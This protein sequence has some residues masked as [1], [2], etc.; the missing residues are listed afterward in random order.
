MQALQE[1]CRG[2]RG[3]VRLNPP[4][5]EPMREEGVEEDLLSAVQEALKAGVAPAE[6]WKQMILGQGRRNSGSV[7]VL[8]CAW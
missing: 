4:G 2:S 6:V 8:P 7:G 3:R 1:E 5:M